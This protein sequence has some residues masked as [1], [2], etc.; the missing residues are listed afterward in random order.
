QQPEDL[1]RIGCGYL[2]NLGHFR[3]R[4]TPFVLSLSKDFPSSRRRGLSTGSA[5]TVL[6]R[7]ATKLRI[8]ATTNASRRRSSA[9]AKP[10]KRR[11][12]WPSAAA[13]LRSALS[14][15]EPKTLPTPVAA[16]PAAIAGSPGPTRFGGFAALVL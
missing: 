5:Q 16:M 2:G 7:Y 6:D 10:M 8:I 13:G 4:I 1:R 11:P 3:V 15:N 9:A 14:R 12:C